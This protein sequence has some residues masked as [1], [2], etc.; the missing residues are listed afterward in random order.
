[1][2]YTEELKKLQYKHAFLHDELK[3]VE[4]QIKYVNSQI[5]KQCQHDTIKAYRDYDGHKTQINYI[6]K[7][8]HKSF[9]LK[10]LSNAKIEYH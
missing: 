5:Q 3:V 7:D 10:E 4:N 6:C 2:N 1:M 8:C 9:E